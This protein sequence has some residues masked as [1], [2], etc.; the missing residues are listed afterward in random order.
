MDVHSSWVEEEKECVGPQ[1]REE[2]SGG[3]RQ[4]RRIKKESQVRE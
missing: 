2:H 4:E 3:W 1:R